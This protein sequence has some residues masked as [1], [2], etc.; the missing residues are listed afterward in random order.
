[1]RLGWCAIADVEASQC[2][3]IPSSQAFGDE[4]HRRTRQRL[5]IEDNSRR[6]ISMETSGKQSWSINGNWRG[7][8]F[9]L[10]ANHATEVDHLHLIDVELKRLQ[11]FAGLRKE[12]N[13]ATV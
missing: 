10:K 4:N 2:R 12:M 8:S 9:V 5:D 3:S 7:R 1:M 6:S 13:V 11:P